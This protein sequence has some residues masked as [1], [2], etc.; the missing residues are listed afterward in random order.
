[1]ETTSA[2]NELCLLWDFQPDSSK[3]S[4]VLWCGKPSSLATTDADQICIVP[5]IVPASEFP[6]SAGSYA[7]RNRRI[8]MGSLSET[9]GCQN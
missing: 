7:H 9:K 5:G 8:H 6:C 4:T 2:S 1:M 3:K